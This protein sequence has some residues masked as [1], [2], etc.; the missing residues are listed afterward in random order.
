MSY[1]ISILES[2]GKNVLDYLLSI[3]SDGDTILFAIDDDIYESK[4]FDGNKED[5]A[6]FETCI[7]EYI[8][9]KRNG[10]SFFDNDNIA[11]ALAAHQ[12]KLAYDSKLFEDEKG[13]EH[14]K[15]INQ[16]LLEFYF[17]DEKDETSIYKTYYASLNNEKENLQDKLWERIRI[18]LNN[19]NRK[20]II[21]VKLQAGN[22]E[23][24]YMYAQLVVLRSLKVYFSKVF[25]FAGISNNVLYTRKE[26]ENCIRN[27]LHVNN[28]TLL[29]HILDEILERLKKYASE[30]EEISFTYDERILIGQLWNFYNSWD[31]TTPYSIQN[32]DGYS[33]SSFFTIELFDEDDGTPAFFVAD[34]PLNYELTKVNIAKNIYFRLLAP[35]SDEWT[36]KAEA[37]NCEIPECSPFVILVEKEELDRFSKKDCTLYAGTDENTKRYFAIKYT[38]K[39]DDFY[40]KLSDGV[41]TENQ[42]ISLIGGLRLTRNEYLDVKIDK[43]L[44][45]VCRNTN[46]K[47]KEYDMKLFKEIEILNSA[48]DCV[49]RY[50]LIPHHDSVK[51]DACE[52]CS[53]IEVEG[54]KI[55]EKKVKPIKK[56]IPTEVP[57]FVFRAYIDSKLLEGHGIPYEK[58]L[59]QIK[60][61]GFVNICNINDRISEEDKTRL[62]KGIAFGCFNVEEDQTL[63]KNKNAIKQIEFCVGIAKVRVSYF[64]EIT[65]FKIT[66]VVTTTTL[67]NGSIIKRNH[68]GLLGYHVKTPTIDANAV[69]DYVSP[70]ITGKKID[71]T[72][73]KE[74]TSEVA[75]STE[76]EFGDSCCYKEDLFC[77]QEALYLWLKH[78]GYAS[79]I[80][81]HNQCAN[82]VQTSGYYSEFGERPEYK[83][84]MP[85][86]KL[87]LIEIY[88]FE[89]E[90]V[91]CVAPRVPLFK[92]EQVS[93][94][95]FSYRNHFQDETDEPIPPEKFSKKAQKLLRE[96]PTV[97]KLITDNSKYFATA[98]Q[99]TINSK[100]IIIYSTKK[101]KRE[102]RSVYHIMDDTPCLFKYT[103]EVYEPAYFCLNKTGE[104]YI[105]KRN[106]PDALTVCKAFINA[107]RCKRQSNIAGNSNN[108]HLFSYYPKEKK[109]VCHYFPDVP[110]WYV[111]ALVLNNPEILEDDEIYLSYCANHYE[112][113]FTGVSEEVVQLL[114]EKYKI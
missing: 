93:R 25:Y 85:L 13:N 111:R 36:W 31:G 114:D 98:D 62:K 12:I 1:T 71:Y 104:C 94:S 80:Q 110:V 33:V 39:P 106:I 100:G 78:K 53:V 21:P 22:R 81:I 101:Y 56:K 58:L 105:I 11:L 107:E 97:S 34:K 109:L 2:F 14:K 51:P 52:L 77:Y 3:S 15:S 38:R 102:M 19:N 40:A 61:V 50:K 89:E 66:E 72:V 26:F 16:T 108:S 68:K 8:A 69:M 59:V 92:T 44:P 5:K 28:S 48:S 63:S 29:K 84:F 18:I 103:K 76:K 67:S 99:I 45:Q 74:V 46:I 41:Q 112:Q 7:K 57:L 96:L 95:G 20:C 60:G 64:F 73:I 88:R 4:I 113:T 47:Q 75:N 37:I 42:K 30:E 24:K 79:W 83:I 86:Y 6:K 55:S 82:L 49:F 43:A 54:L 87:G 70:D 17:P 9:K 10:L 32:D 91:F 27:N 35:H 23:Q 90:Y 65:G